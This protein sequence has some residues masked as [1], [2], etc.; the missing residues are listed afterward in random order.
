MPETG[1]SRHIPG[2]AGNRPFPDEVRNPPR[3]N[4][5]VLFPELARMSLFSGVPRIQDSDDFKLPR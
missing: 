2:L 5:R 3:S 1:T 4:Q